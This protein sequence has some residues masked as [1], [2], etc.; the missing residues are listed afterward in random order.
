MPNVC[1]HG[2]CLYLKFALKETSVFVYPIKVPAESID[3]SI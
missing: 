2:E 3:P 1:K